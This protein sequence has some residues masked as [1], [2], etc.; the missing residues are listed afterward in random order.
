MSACSPSSLRI[1]CASEIGEPAGSPSTPP[2]HQNRADFHGRHFQLTG[3]AM[4]ST[5]AAKIRK[6][7]REL[8]DPTIAEHSQRFFKTGPG[9]Y[10]EG[11]K[12]IGIRVPVLRR[13]AKQHREIPLSDAAKL[14]Q[15]QVHEERLL[16]LLILVLK[17]DKGDKSARQEVFDLYCRNLKFV[18]NWDLVDSSA[19][20]IV[21]PQ[22]EHRSRR[23][24]HRWAK[25]KNLW[26][27]RIAIMSTFAYIKQ[28]EFE[29]SLTIAETLL[30]DEED[31]IHKAV[32]WMLREIGNRDRGAEEAFL[33]KHYQTMPRT[34]LRYAIEKFPET[35]RKRYLAGN[36]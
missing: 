18:N 10:G 6:Q 17:Y 14:L 2:L 21:G 11:D 7:L 28:G 29:E 5:T 32:G 31:L 9:E 23:K 3:Q 12:F 34:M 1:T 19:H 8:A 25:S 15:S 33:K 16:A 20:L 27:R 13:I 30:Q 36:V 35:K 22:L 24:L 26:Q 4:S